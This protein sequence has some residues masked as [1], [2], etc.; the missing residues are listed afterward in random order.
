METLQNTLNLIE[1]V[2]DR[3]TKEEKFIDFADLPIEEQ[4]FF[5]NLIDDGLITDEYFPM[6]DKDYRT[7][8]AMKKYGMIE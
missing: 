1:D 6:P 8:M 2:L 4:E 7:W 3:Y 5:Q